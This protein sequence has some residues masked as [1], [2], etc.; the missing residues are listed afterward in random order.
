MGS[1]KKQ[2]S[3]KNLYVIIIAFIILA[4]F[5]TLMPYYS[6]KVMNGLRG[7]LTAE[8][9]WSKAQKTAIHELIRYGTYQEEEY[10][11]NFN[12]NLEILQGSKDARIALLAENPDYEV[13][14][15]RFQQG[16]VNPEF[17]DDMNWLFRRFRNFEIFNEALEHWEEGDEYVEKLH[18][19]SGEIHNEIENGTLDQASRNAYLDELYEIDA[20]LH[21][22]VNEFVIIVEDAISSSRDYILVSNIL[23][24]ILMIGLAC[25]VTVILFR[26]ANN[27]NDR[28]SETK[29]KFSHVLDN[30]RD[31]I[32][33]MDAEGKNFEYVS[34]VV[35]TMLGYKVEELMEKGP[36]FILEKVH[37]DDLKRIQDARKQ[38][39]YRIPQQE[40]ELDTEYRLQTT[41]G[42]YIWVNNRRSVVTDENGNYH[43]VVGNVR[44]I[45]ERKTHLEQL[46]ESLKEKDTLL[47][48]IHHRVKNNLAIISSL[49]E[50]HKKEHD[51]KIQ[52]T[53]KDL[54][55][56]IKTI[57]LVHEKL[58]QN[59]SFGEVEL[60][61]YVNGLVDLVSKSMISIDKQ[62]TIERDLDDIRFNLTNAVPFGLIC[63]EL[64]SNAYKHAF[65][66]Q[67]EGVIRL[68]LRKEGDKGVFSVMDNGA[69]LP[70]DFG[71]KNHGTLGMTL[72]D[73]LACQLKGELSINSGDW[74]EFKVSFQ[75]EE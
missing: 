19:I 18:N 37:P 71:I 26:K 67:K 34:P 66:D 64:I 29:E 55:A 48:E 2:I 41:N 17:I 30:S 69:G 59:D 32:Y 61:E 75:V 10:W 14:S 74:T 56:R 46:D 52:V 28:L 47:A 21:H 13:A 40:M 57:A 5:A 42:H 62:I 35:E 15:D 60:S 65:N 38:T 23:L 16:G 11:E 72:V 9:R 63:N 68:V 8:S 27:L 6:I 25:I 51:E 49:I 12:D 43:G 4:I 36:E 22:L 20:R 53:L 45:T 33:Q 73:N 54:Q 70:G 1:S 3:Q 24:G 58:Y 7:Y 31:I 44:D 39:A 50:M